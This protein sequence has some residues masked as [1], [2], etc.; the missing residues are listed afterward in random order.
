VIAACVQQ[1]KSVYRFLCQAIAAWFENRPAP[2][3]L[4]AGAGG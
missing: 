4:P 2:S 1:G 3:L